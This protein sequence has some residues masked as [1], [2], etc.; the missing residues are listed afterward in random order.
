MDKEEKQV[1]IRLRVEQ[2][3]EALN[4]TE[5]LLEGNRLSTAV[6]RLYY[7]VF[8]ML[9]AFA[10]KDGFSTSKHAQLIG[11]F[12]KTYIHSHSIDVKYSNLI[13]QIFKNREKSD[14][15]FLFSMTR[16]QVESSLNEIKEL[17]DTLKELLKS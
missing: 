13:Y 12:N 11:W 14:Y 2:S 3:D 16:E 5:Y 4:D 15:D 1:L 7:A 17:I 6:N 10:L 9:S 8:Y